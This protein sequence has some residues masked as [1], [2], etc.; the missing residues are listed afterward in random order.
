[1]D[2]SLKNR[3]QEVLDLMSLVPSLSREKEQEKGIKQKTKTQSNIVKV[4]LSEEY[5][6]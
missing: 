1:M 3:R 2:R 4:G 6:E 5:T